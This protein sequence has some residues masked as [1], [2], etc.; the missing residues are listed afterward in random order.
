MPEGRPCSPESDGPR[1]PR[2]RRGRSSSAASSSHGA[3]ALEP[4]T[5]C[6]TMVGLLAL[7][8]ER[9]CE[10]ELAAAIE[11]ALDQGCLPDL[12]ELTRRFAP[13]QSTSPT[14]TVQLPLIAA[15]DSLLATVE[16]RP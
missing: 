15:Y 16:A 9:G 2:A 11:A 13:K 10:S 6:R 3:S 5:A 12:A 14:V 8:H 1:T 7:A 4:A